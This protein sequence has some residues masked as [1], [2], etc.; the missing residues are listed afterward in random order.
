[1]K[2]HLQYP[3]LVTRLRERGL[4]V[5]SDV[6]AVSTLKR[7][8]YYRLSGYL[9]PFRE[10][11]ENGRGDRYVPGAS[12]DD[13]VALYDFDE[14][15]RSIL[16]EGLSI[17]EV[18]LGARLAH[19]LGSLD[20]EAHLMREHLDAAACSKP[21]VH[22]GREM[23]GHDAFVARYEHLRGEAKEEAYVKHHILNHDG[24]IPLWAAVQFFDFGCLLRLYNLARKK[25][26]RKVADVFGLA[27]DRVGQ[28][29]K[30]L[31]PL[32]VLRNDCAHNNRV[33]NRS[34]IYPP[35]R[36]PDRMVTTEILHLN[37]LDEPERH[38]LYP[39]AALVA[40]FI[41]KLH[42]DSG[43][44][45]RFRD[46]VVAFGQVGGMTPETSMGFPTSWNAMP[47]WNPTGSAN[48]SDGT[49]AS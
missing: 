6:D 32:N 22:Q 29:A 25:E 37:S 7:V 17:V 5:R 46:C 9:Y 49:G 26:Q 8:G 14:R 39:L 31:R 21:T 36:I 41:L 38:R 3:E 16:G 40:Y 44:I 34:T 42:R 2:Q 28:L 35:S 1:M 45:E 20:P 48:L 15:L 19:V 4:S 13:G 24:H 30:L 27:D 47:L 10:Q 43:W 12:F 23:D 18:A 11:L 33:W